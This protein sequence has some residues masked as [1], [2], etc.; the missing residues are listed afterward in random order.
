MGSW[1][2]FRMPL[3]CGS[4]CRPFDGPND[5]PEASDGPGNTVTPRATSKVNRY[6]LAARI[7]LNSGTQSANTTVISTF[8]WRSIRSTATF[9]DSIQTFLDRFPICPLSYAKY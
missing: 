7:A 8:A 1:C 3:A 5:T 4:R 6:H 9:D 2:K